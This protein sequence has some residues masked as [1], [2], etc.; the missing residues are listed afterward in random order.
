VKDETKSRKNTTVELCGHHRHW[1][2][3]SQNKKKRSYLCLF[4]PISQSVQ[5]YTTDGVFE[6]AF[7]YRLMLTRTA[8]SGRNSMAKNN[9]KNKKDEKYRMKEFLDCEP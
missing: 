2:S 5:F 1:S 9:K 8:R 3:K 4:L 7:T 6:N